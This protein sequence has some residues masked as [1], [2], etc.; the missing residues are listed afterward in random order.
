M[1]LTDRT[2]TLLA[3]LPSLPGGFFMSDILR[4]TIFSF[5]VPL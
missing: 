2:V 1:G 3:G 5:D 4:G